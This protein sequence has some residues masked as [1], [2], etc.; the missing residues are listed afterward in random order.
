MVFSEACCFFGG[1]GKIAYEMSEAVTKGLA[2][3]VVGFHNSV[4]GSTL[5]NYYTLSRFFMEIGMHLSIK[6]K[7][8]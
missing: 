5:E 8:K 1:N 3:S 7:V 6:S 4:I 2:S